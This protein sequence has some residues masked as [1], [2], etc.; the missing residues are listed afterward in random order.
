[1]YIVMIIVVMHVDII[2]LACN[3]QK[4]NIDLLTPVF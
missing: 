2:Y 3:G 4:G 1:M